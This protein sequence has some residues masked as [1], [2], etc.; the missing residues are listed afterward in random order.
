MLADDLGLSLPPLDQSELPLRPDLPLSRPPLVVAAAHALYQR[1]FAYEL[2]EER[3]EDVLSSP[4]YA[5]VLNLS[6]EL[7][8]CVALIEVEALFVGPLLRPHPYP[9]RS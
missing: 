5:F 4:V 1:V 2:A 8:I 9:C 7:L 6:L 3:G